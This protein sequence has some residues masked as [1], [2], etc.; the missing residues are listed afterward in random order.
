[1]QSTESCA[2]QCR[3]IVPLCRAIVPQLMRPLLADMASSGDHYQANV[4]GH[5]HEWSRETNSCSIEMTISIGNVI[6][7]ASGPRY[8]MAFPAI[9]SVNGAYI[10]D[11]AGN[12]FPGHVAIIYFHHYRAES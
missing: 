6:R 7:V 11:H 2:A 3:A 12:I 8:S 5:P 4:P 10:T 1:M 9:L